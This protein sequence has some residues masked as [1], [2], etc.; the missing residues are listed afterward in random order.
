MRPEISDGAAAVGGSAGPASPLDDH[1]A[2]RLIRRRA[3]PQD[4]VL[5]GR[6]AVP[7]SSGRP[8]PAWA[9]SAARR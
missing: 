8:E 6:T 5:A 3:G 9:F 2:S 4:R 1:P 7:Y